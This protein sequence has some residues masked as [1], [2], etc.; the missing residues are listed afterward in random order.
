[1]LL[2][3]PE[4]G[5]LDAFLPELTPGDADR[6]MKARGAVSSTFLAGLELAREGDLALW[7]GQPYG[8]VFFRPPDAEKMVS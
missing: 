4:G 7:Q 1:L 3:H 8:P 6:E 5:A 2:I